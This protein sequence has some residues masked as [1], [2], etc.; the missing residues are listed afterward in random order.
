MQLPWQ[1]YLLHLRLKKHYIGVSWTLNFWP[2]ILSCNLLQLNCCSKDLMYC[3]YEGREWLLG[4]I[5]V[6]VHR[7]AWMLYQYR[8]LVMLCL[9]SV[10]ASIVLTLLQLI[11]LRH[12]STEW[13]IMAMLSETGLAVHDVPDRLLPR[14]SHVG[15]A[16]SKLQWMCDLYN[17]LRRMCCW[18]PSWRLQKFHNI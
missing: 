14:H 6:H 15:I 13:W 17:S 9:S 3:Q 18:L 1:R 4:P 5:N 2:W 16:V 7:V 10:F 8:D 11:C 12:C